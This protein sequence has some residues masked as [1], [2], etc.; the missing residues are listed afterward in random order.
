MLIE[1]LSACGCGWRICGREIDGGVFGGVGL[2][3]GVWSFGFFGGLI[4]NSVRFD[5]RHS[6]L[7]C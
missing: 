2:G 1:N 5:I 6:K 7:S 3:F 4:T